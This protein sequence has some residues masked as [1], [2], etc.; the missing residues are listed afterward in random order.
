LP[1]TV[2]E[3]TQPISLVDSLSVAQLLATLVDCQTD[4]A[5]SYN[6]CSLEQPTVKKFLEMVVHLP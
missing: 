6:L 4:L 1:L 3:E 2:D 5:P